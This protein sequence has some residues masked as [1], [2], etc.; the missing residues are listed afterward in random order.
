ME[1][2]WEDI[3]GYEGHYQVSNSGKVF[4]LKMEIELKPNIIRSGYKMVRL[5][6]HGWARDYLVH[7]LVAMCFVNNPKNNRVVNHLDG[8]KTNNYFLNL[9]WCTD[10]ENQLHAI[11]TGLRVPKSRE[12]HPQHKLSEA[13]IL[14]IRKRH[15]MGLTYKQLACEYN[16]HY[17]TIGRIVTHKI[18][19]EKT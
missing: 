18:W 5:S 6:K 16:V 13:Q 1:E 9:E 2:M 3:P 10:S 12:E 11:R 4:S 7:R 8:N 19:K 17:A 14:E 15:K